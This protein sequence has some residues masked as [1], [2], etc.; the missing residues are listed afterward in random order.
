M[1]TKLLIDAITRQ[2]TVLI[3]QLSSAAGIRAPLAHLADE[4]F[5]HLSEELEE[6][7]LSR[8]V[9]ADMFGMALRGYQRRVQ[10]LRE[11]ATEQGRTL[12][13]AVLDHLQR[14]G[15][16][17]RLQLLERFDSDD[18]EA[19]AAILND[20]VSTGLATRTGSGPTA[21]FSVT[22]EE[23][24]RLLAQGG[25]E[26]LASALVW[27]DLC[28]NPSS[29]AEDIAARIG[30][31]ASVVAE[32]TERLLKQGSA[33]LDPQGRMRTEALIIDVGAEEG[34]ETAVLDHYQ[35]VC[36][37]IAS[38]LQKGTTRSAEA[39]TTGGM[40]LNFEIS[41]D[42][43]LRDRVLGLLRSTRAEANALW[44]EVEALNRQ[45]P[46]REDDI[47]R[48]TFYFGQSVKDNGVKEGDE[49]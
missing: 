20:L 31:E 23:S 41:S 28:R 45:S 32:A 47:T 19:V 35:A 5:L 14:Q 4:V 42:H 27:L 16:A 17:S 1:Q 15:P 13:E 11:S 48:V 43:P 30:V 7:G 29:T 10:R 2:T 36:S 24:R 39:D 44:D 49:P 21:V 22:P 18:P 34:W 9:V 8:K 6:Q 33:Q 38:K 25:H 46:P 12:W 37:A 26:Q 40:T 3:A